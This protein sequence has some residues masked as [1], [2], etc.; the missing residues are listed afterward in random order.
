VGKKCLSW[1]IVR[2]L[3]DSRPDDD[4]VYGTWQDQALNLLVYKPRAS[5]LG[6]SAPILLYIHGGGFSL[7]DRFESGTNLRWFADRGWL[8]LS[9]D[10]T[11]SSVDRHLWDTTRFLP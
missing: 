11:L 9:I 7:G 6:Q 5:T 10:Y 2:L 4:L 3:P 8:A 1:L